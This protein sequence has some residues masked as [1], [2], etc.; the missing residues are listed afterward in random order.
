MGQSGQMPRREA[1]KTAGAIGVGGSRS[2]GVEAAA[3][4]PPYLLLVD[5]VGGSFFGWL[6]FLGA[7]FFCGTC[8]LCG[9]FF[10]GTGD[11]VCPCAGRKCGVVR[12]GVSGKFSTSRSTN[13]IM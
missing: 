7:F 1:L 4:I 6:G 9:T 2:R 3:V 8:R 10:A 13:S 5:R 12:R 11:P